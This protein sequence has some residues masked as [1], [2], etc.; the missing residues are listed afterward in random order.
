MYWLFIDGIKNS[1]EIH[2]TPPTW[3]PQHPDWRSWTD[4]N[5]VTSWQLLG[6]FSYLKNSLILVGGSWGFQ[7][8]VSVTA[9]YSLSRLRP[10]FGN[11]ILGFFFATLLVPPITY[12]I[13][14]YIN[15]NSLPLVHW[16]IATGNWVFLGV[17]LPEAANAFNLYIL[18]SFFD[19]LPEEIM[20]AARIDG[21]NALDL[22][23]RIVLPMSKA[24]LAVITILT[25]MA[26]WKDF[27]W[28]YVVTSGDPDHQPL[29][30]S[31]YYA[32][33]N[34]SLGTPDN[35]MFAAFALVSIPPIVLFLIFQRQ[36]IRGISLTGLT[37]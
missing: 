3:I 14:Q 37:G 22:L 1:T 13:P 5:F 25:V 33:Y 28:P 12:L 10:A 34:R 18:K 20:D 31:L 30:V 17:L 4:N 19:D 2:V 21:A 23:V 9:A 24:V 8:L 6:L 7:V 15:I 16:N 11:I 29:M 36:I 32:W 35:V 26:A 27:T